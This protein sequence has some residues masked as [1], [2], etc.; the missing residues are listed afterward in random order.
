MIVLVSPDNPT[1]ST[2]GKE[3]LEAVAEIAVKHNL[4]VISDEIY[5]KFT[6]GGRKHYSIASMEGM[7][8][9]TMTL[10]G[11]SKAYAMTGF[12]VGYLATDKTLMKKI[13]PL[14]V[15]IVTCTNAIGQ[16]AA[17]EALR[18]PQNEVEAM[19]KEYEERSNTLADGFNHMPGIICARPGG[20]MYVYPNI[21]SFKMTSGEFSV[22]IAKEAN[23]L[24]YPATVFGNGGEGYLR[25]VITTNRDGIYDPKVSRRNIAEGL[26]RI[27]KAIRKLKK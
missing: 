26:E 9:R 6:F 11:F 14:H 12:R 24:V 27:E 18:G 22:H 25:V 19:W 17:V 8:E 5:E 10:N 3:D 2:L 20:S 15:Q 7:K 1:G 4:L 21:K 16:K 23:V 13:S